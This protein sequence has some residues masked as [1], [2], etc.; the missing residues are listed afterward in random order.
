MRA[1]VRDVALQLKR[2]RVKPAR[3]FW[4]LPIEYRF[5]PRR[6]EQ[7]LLPCTVRTHQRHHQIKYLHSTLE[8]VDQRSIT[9]PRQVDITKLSLRD[10]YLSAPRRALRERRFK[11]AIEIE[12][13]RDDRLKQPAH[14][15]S[16]NNLT[17]LLRHTQTENH[18]KYKHAV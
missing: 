9:N 14:L 7:R 3:R 15:V 2:V 18:E 6:K 16:F 17:R 10:R 4:W 11:R 12:I 13:L 5:Y 1:Q 8:R